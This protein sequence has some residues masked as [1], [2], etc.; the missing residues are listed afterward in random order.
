MN[1]HDTCFFD[2]FFV[3]KWPEQ[4]A[5]YTE[6]SLL[7]FWCENQVEA[8]TIGEGPV[9]H[10]QHLLFWVA[11]LEK[12]CGNHVKN[13]TLCH[14]QEKNGG[15]LNNP[16]NLGEHWRCSGF[17]IWRWT[18][19]GLERSERAKW[20]ILRCHIKEKLTFWVTLPV[21]IG[22]LFSN[23][24]SMQFTPLGFTETLS[25]DWVWIVMEQTGNAKA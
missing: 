19:C 20:N 24:L 6:D 3:F 13:A 10:Q 4:M 14:W 18:L 23:K 12:Q 25:C 15:F 7:A 21:P 17:A 11:L 22:Q 16:G 5:S 9:K 2:W 1:K 8:L